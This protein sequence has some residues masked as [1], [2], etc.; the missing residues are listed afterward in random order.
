MDL[1]VVKNRVAGQT[2]LVRD[3]GGRP[4]TKREQQIIA[5]VLCG[6]TNREIAA[7]FG[8]SEHTVKA[9]LGKLYAKAGV[10]NRLELALRVL[11]R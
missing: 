8:I 7:A 5:R 6:E 10:K 9:Q 11:R 3:I 2:R 1:E 4:L